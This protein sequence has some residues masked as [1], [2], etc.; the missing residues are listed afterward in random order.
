LGVLLISSEALL[1]LCRFLMWE[2]VLEES[3]VKV[4]AATKV[5]AKE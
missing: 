4:G 1:R 2:K 3:W 5:G